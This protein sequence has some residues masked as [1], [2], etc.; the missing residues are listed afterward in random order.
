MTDPS[1]QQTGKPEDREHPI[2]ATHISGGVNVSADQASIEGDAVGRDKIS[3]V[4]HTDT[5][6]GANVGGDVTVGDGGEFV[7]RDKTTNN[8]RQIVMKP[9]AWLVSIVILAIALVLFA[10]IFNIDP[11]RGLLP[12]PMPF[13]PAAEN[14][15][16]IIVADFE[17]RGAG[18][19]RGI[20]PAQYIYEELVDQAR[21]DGLTDV[22]IE[23]LREIVD[24][25]SA[26]PVGQVYS[27]TLV[28]WGWYDALT[29]TPRIERLK[30]LSDY[31]ST[32]EGQHLSLVD[33][34]KVEFSVFTDLPGQS[35]YLALFTLGLDRLKSQDQTDA[36]AY[37]NSALESATVDKAVS[38]NLYE[39]YF[40]RAVAYQ[41]QSDNNAAILDYTRA[42][43]LKPDFV[44][45]YINR[46]KVYFDKGDHDRS[47]ADVNEAIKLGSRPLDLAMGHSNRGSIYAAQ[48]DFERAMFDYNLAIN[49]SPD[50]ADAYA[51]RGSAYGSLGDYREGLDDLT[52]AIALKPE[53]AKAYYSRGIIRYELDD[54]EGAVADF[55]RAIGLS[56]DY[57]EAYNNRGVAYRDKGDLNRAIADYD[58]AIDLKGDNFEAYTNRGNAYRARGEYSLA[59]ADYSKAIDLKPGDPDAY[60]SR[61]TVYQFSGDINRAITDLNQA[62]KLGPENA[63]AYYIRG[64]MYS[65]A[66]DYERG[67]SDFSRAIELKH[68]FADAYFYRGLAYSGLALK[69]GDNDHARVLADYDQAINFNPKFADAYNNRCYELYESSLYL[70]ALPDCEKAVQLKPNEAN[71]LDSRAAVYRALKRT[72]DAIADYERILQ[73]TDNPELVKTAQQALSELRK[74]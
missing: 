39:A 44:A 5:G 35:T 19:Y 70:K 37:F 4:Q 10:G 74:P 61:G 50:Y 45:A 33:P 65:A 9:W 54:L 14:Q 15:S 21:K 55:D 25:N 38:L 27:A 28:V 13:P 16:L 2:Q 22:R 6:G 73:L 8:F 1:L 59:V 58:K 71:F 31:R 51:N 3:S 47:L 46:G 7:G 34:E 68:D 20:D 30:P 17:D 52:R 53:N 36:I 23:R 24:D 57:S 49:L 32:E 42:M 64:I 48:G 72:N 56:P 69:S 43:G 41:L 60:M 29:I 11:L 12:T 63:V 18:R 40:F 26:R 67:I 66:N 62:I